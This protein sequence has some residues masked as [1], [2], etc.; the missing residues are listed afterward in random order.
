MRYVAAM[1]LKSLI[2]LLDEPTNYLDVTL[3]YYGILHLQ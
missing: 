3:N 1:L 2:F